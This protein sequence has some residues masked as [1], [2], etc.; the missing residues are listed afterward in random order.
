MSS[1]QYY[2]YL[3]DENVKN[4]NFFYPVF[5]SINYTG[6]GAAAVVLITGVANTSNINGDSVWNYGDGVVDRTPRLRHG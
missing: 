2:G 3:N 5:Y 1:Q 6:R 4:S